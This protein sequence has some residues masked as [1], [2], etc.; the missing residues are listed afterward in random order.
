MTGAELSILASAAFGKF[1]LAPLA[2]RIGIR[3]HNLIMWKQGKVPL[4]R[5]Q[6]VID[7]CLDEARKNLKSIQ[8]ITRH[9]KYEIYRQKKLEEARE[10]RRKVK[11]RTTAFARSRKKE[12]ERY[13]KYRAKSDAA[14]LGHQ[15]RR[16]RIVSRETHPAQAPSL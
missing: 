16:S 4:S 7:L 15:R 3:H 12:L 1:W 8:R 2:R 10:A 11:V 9:L 6:Q 13:L 14:T 5:E